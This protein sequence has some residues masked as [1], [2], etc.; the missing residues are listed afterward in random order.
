VLIKLVYHSLASQKYELYLTF[1]TNIVCNKNTP[2]Q[3]ALYAKSVHDLSIIFYVKK[4]MK[5]HKFQ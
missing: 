4:G 1:V 5:R 2:K 3:I